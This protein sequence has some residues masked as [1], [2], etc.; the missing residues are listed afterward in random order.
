MNE[1]SI[2][3][4]YLIKNLLNNRF[5]VGQTKRDIKIRWV[6]H[7]R[8]SS[9][10]KDDDFLHCD[11][12]AFGKEHFSIEKIEETYIDN[13]INREK[14]WISKLQTNIRR[15]PSGNGYNLTDG[16]GGSQ[17]YVTQETKDKIRN[18][19]MGHVT[20]QETKDKISETLNGR[21]LTEEHRNNIGIGLKKSDKFKLSSKN[22][23]PASQETKDKI[24]IS[25][26]KMW[27]DEQFQYKMSLLRQGSHNSQAKMNEDN[28]IEIKTTWNVER[29]D[30][31]LK[32]KHD[33]TKKEFYVRF[34]DKFGVT[35][36]MIC[37]I[38]VNRA[39]KHLDPQIEK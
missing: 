12:K 23:G 11:I 17:S 22:K 19:L 28:V 39:W 37:R 34:A 8:L 10:C 21:E 38:I 15:Y 1:Q 4:I 6:E 25:S 2:G 13:L 7:L 18:S 35:P 27:Q 26:L 31:K 29:P 30:L 14:F 9:R 3:F 36:D 32:H 16:G 33:G 24:S 5:Y 20:L